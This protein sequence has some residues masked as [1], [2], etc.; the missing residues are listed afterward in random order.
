MLRNEECELVLFTTE[1]QHTVH[2]P[3]RFCALPGSTL[4]LQYVELLMTG[5]VKTVYINFCKG[6]ASPYCVE[7]PICRKLEQL[8]LEPEKEMNSQAFH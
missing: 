2:P 4:W 6:F 8:L 1:T 5:T 3:Q 7:E